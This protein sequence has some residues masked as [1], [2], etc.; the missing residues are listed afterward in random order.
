MTICT[1]AQF[2]S[3]MKTF[4]VTKWSIQ[5]SCPNNHTYHKKIMKYWVSLF[6]PFLI[7]R[8]LSQITIYNH[9]THYWRNNM[10]VNLI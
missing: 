2:C 6:Q 1:K 4:Q 3:K 5:Q 7:F 10:N 9:I 8:I